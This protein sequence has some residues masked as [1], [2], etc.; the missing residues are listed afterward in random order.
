MIDYKV[1][2]G[3]AVLS[4]NLPDRSM[5]VLNEG[6]LTAYAEALERAVAD[7]AVTGII[8]TSGKDSFLAGAD[9]AMVKGAAFG[10]KDPAVLFERL[11][12]LQRLFRRQ[13]SCGKP[14]VAA[15]N[16]TALGG[17]LELC[18]AAHYRIAADN[19]RAELGLPEVK[20]GLLPGGGGTQRLPRMIGLQPAMQAILKG[21]SFSPQ[22]A[23]GMKIVDEVVPAADLMARA[24]AYLKGSPRSVQPWDERGFRI[25]GGAVQS[26]MGFQTFTAGNAVVVKET[27]GNYPAAKAIMSCFYEGL[28]VGIDAGLTIETRYFTALILDPVAGNMIRT[29]FVNMQDLNKGARRPTGEPKTEVRKLGILGAGM[30]GAGI[31]YVSSRA[32]IDCVLLDTAIEAAEKG[33][34]YSAGLLDKAVSRGKATAEKREAQL[35]RIHTTTDYADL[36]G[37]DLVI[38][39][40]FESREVKAG[41]TKQAEAVLGPDAV[42]ASNTSTLPISSL[43]EASRDPGAFI[44]IHFFSPVDKMMLVEIIMGAETSSRALAVAMDYV[45]KIKKT[46]IVVNDRRGFYTSRCF[47]TYVSEGIEMLAEGIA[48]AIIDN[49]GRAA[50]MPRGPLEMNDD[51]ALDLGWKIRCAAR[52]DLGDAYELLPGEAIVEALVDRL[53]RYGRKNGKGFYEYPADAKKY[54]WPGLAELAPVRVSEAD[55]AL[56]KEIRTRL[57]YR[58]AIEAARCFAEGVVTDIRDADVGAILAWGFAPWTGGPLSLIDTVGVARFVA[59]CDALAAR[60]GQRYSPP[61]L[62]RDMAKAGRSFYQA[63]TAQAA[64]AE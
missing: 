41:V 58:Q 12:A 8:V 22:D 5:N 28:Q 47:G 31:A 61:Q 25:P 27:Y 52:K 6:S 43:A 48:P 56:A 16:G 45:Q 57:L 50:G 64:A 51:V 60:F 10:A 14:V 32:G 23:L 13:E 55:P 38:E 39:A 34:A 1:E 54:L 42:F 49:V 9:L 11:G 53:G 44:G 2:D 19:P 20:V 63:D 18:L 21:T 30:M 29:L 17:G 36:A 46:P 4:W 35:A 7:P 33:K 3:V 24:R 62:L 37:C 40:V 15:I 59:E 26:P